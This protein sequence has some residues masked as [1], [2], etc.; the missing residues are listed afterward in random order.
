MLPVVVCYIP[1][2]NVRFFIVVVVYNSKLSP[3]F[4]YFLFD[5]HFITAL[6]VLI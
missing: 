5:V 4:N 3:P 1:C 2:L 6:M